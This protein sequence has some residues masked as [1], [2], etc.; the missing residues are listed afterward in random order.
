MTFGIFPLVGGSKPSETYESQLGTLLPTNGKIKMF[1]NTNQSCNTLTLKSLNHAVVILLT[2]P[3]I[4]YI[5]SFYILQELLM[6]GDVVEHIST[7]NKSFYITH[8]TG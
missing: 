4:T 5:N 7:I 2:D 1:Q 3:V 8:R 6:D